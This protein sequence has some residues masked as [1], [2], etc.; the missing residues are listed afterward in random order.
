VAVPPIKRVPTK[1]TTYDHTAQPR[2][3]LRMPPISRP[4]GLPPRNAAPMPA[5]ADAMMTTRSA[6]FV[7][8]MSASTSS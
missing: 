7:A 3:A 8:L 5:A 1:Y 2:S 6:W 4:S